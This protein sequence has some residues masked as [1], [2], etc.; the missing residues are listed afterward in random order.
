M[1]KNRNFRKICQETNTA[2]GTLFEKLM[3]SS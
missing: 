2:P 3:Q 1:T